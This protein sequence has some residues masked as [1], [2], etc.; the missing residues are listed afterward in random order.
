MSEQYVGLM[1]QTDES[2][3]FVDLKVP[4]TILPLINGDFSVKLEALRG[5]NDNFYYALRDDG[6]A[7]DSLFHLKFIVNSKG[8]KAGES[9]I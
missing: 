2:L 4:K 9:Y 8:K 6:A 7:S 5:L 1:I 3:F